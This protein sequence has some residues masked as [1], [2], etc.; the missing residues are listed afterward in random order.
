MLGVQKR[1]GAIRSSPYKIIIILSVL[2]FF[3]ALFICTGV[4]FAYGIMQLSL[5]VII[6]TMSLFWA[7]RWPYSFRR[8]K[9]AGRLRYVHALS[10]ALALLLPATTL[11]QLKDG[12]IATAYPTLV[13][14]GRDTSTIYYFLVMPLSIILAVTSILK[15]LIFWILLKVCYFYYARSID[16]C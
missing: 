16:E 13:C 7:V 8:V 1:W 4:I 3:A 14:I 10:I 15:V 6:H 2:L 11:I 12:Y 9:V 5:W